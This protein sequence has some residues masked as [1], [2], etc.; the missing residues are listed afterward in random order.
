MLQILRHYHCYRHVRYLLNIFVRRR[1]KMLFGPFQNR[2][3]QRCFRRSIYAQPNSTRIGSVGYSA[4]T[5]ANVSCYDLFHAL[6]CTFRL[7]P[8]QPAIS[9]TN[10]IIPLSTS[11]PDESFDA[12]A[13]LRAL[14]FAEYPT[15]LRRGYLL[16]PYYLY[17][18][19]LNSVLTRPSFSYY[20]Y[21]L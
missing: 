19:W 4:L 20:A 8:P 7:K 21:L 14:S 12:F 18:A 11:R 2:I 1:Q 16:L 10:I 9:D 6:R 15:N 3:Q 5:T 13:S 17:I